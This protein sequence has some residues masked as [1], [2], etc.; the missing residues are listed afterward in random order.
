MQDLRYA[1]RGLLRRPMFA[2]AAILAAALGVGATTAVFSAVDRI[3]FRP[4]PYGHEDRLMSVGMMAPLD[5]NEF[6]FASE[7]FDLRHAPGPFEAVTS[8]EAGA[9]ACDLTEQQNPL[10]LHCLKVESNFLDV[11]GL[12][13][14]IGRMFTREED[15]RNGPRVTVISYGLW[16]NRFARDPKVIGRTI[17]IDGTPVLVVGVLPATFEM[18][19]LTK[20]DLLLPE[21]LNEATEH[22]GRALRAFGRLKRGIAPAQALSQLQPH[23][24][25]ALETVPPQFRKEV[26]MRVRPV[27]DRQVGEARL[28][29]LVLFGAVLSVMLIA[30]AN[31]A[32]LLVARAVSR[33]R[34]MAMRTAMG[35]SR[36]RI[37]RQTLTESLLLGVT[38]GAAG[39][40]L[41]YGLLR[42]FIA[43]APGALPRLEDASIDLRVLGLSLALSLISGL[44]FGIAP[45]MH[46]SGASVLA[47]WKSTS[48]V[49]HGLRATLVTVQIAISLVLL[50]S[51]GLPLK[52]L[53]KLENVPL[54]MQTGHVLTAHFT[55][56]RQRYGTGAQ[57]LAFFNELER[58]LAALPG[59]ESSAITDSLP[60]TG[61][62]R[63]RPLAAIAIEGKPPRPEGT[64][65]MVAWR[66][67]TP[68]YFSTLGIPIVRGRAFNEQDRGVND[69]SVVLSKRLAYALFPNEDPLGKHVLK[70]GQGLWFTVVGIADDVK[71]LG[72]ARTSDPKYYLV[73]KPAEDE[74]FRFAEPPTGWRAAYV[75]TRTAIDP[76][77]MAASL[78]GVLGAI[79][80]T[81]PVEMETMP[82]RMD[83]V[84]I[85]PR[86]NALL[87]S[88][89]AAIGVLLAAIGLFGVMSFLVAQRTREI[90]VRMA[91]G[92]TPE[93]ILQMT[94]AQAGLPRLDMSLILWQVLHGLIPVYDGAGRMQFNLQS[95][96][97]PIFSAGKVTFAEER[98]V[99]THAR[100]FG[101]ISVPIGA[102]IYYHVGGSQ[103]HQEQ[104]SGL[105]PIDVG[106]VLITTHALYFGGQKTTLR[107]PLN[108]VVR[109]QSYVDGVGV[110]E[111]HGAPKVFVP[112][113]SGM[114]TGWFFFNLLTALSKALSFSKSSARRK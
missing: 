12:R 109:Y 44:L 10:R 16:Q 24:A 29:S 76:E 8:F 13:P 18:P 57:Q 46:S 56:G 91:L 52:S 105:M 9:P 98:T 47:G 80:P 74:T 73:R 58:R 39:C 100:T 108:R 28:A 6:M 60:P 49:G 113:Y 99:S 14:T 37:M 23:F 31:I 41:A 94:L 2:A 51:A 21:A 38:G 62:S 53:W 95:G 114:D 3:L 75:V 70:N 25:R 40:A 34:E 83:E 107:I 69:F 84:T 7:Y 45:A 36:W 15:R 92:A 85:R 33:D 111:A 48:S 19:T 89:F 81:L 71:N 86:F 61:G 106:E 20:G 64:G 112:D 65:G 1:V 54:G 82:R 93:K 66:Y 77:L 50:T 42:V 43:I 35:A 87:L 5:T 59:A 88:V 63:G 78:R 27:R 4:L 30:C 17:P 96:E 72:P 55:L 97:Q 104:A 110:C 79:D 22:Q 90:G 32:N 68:A 26:S 103:A 67:V 11:L 101:G 102:G